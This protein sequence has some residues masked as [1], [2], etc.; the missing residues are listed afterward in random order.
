MLCSSSFRV[1]TETAQRRKQTNRVVIPH[2]LLDRH[3]DEGESFVDRT[4]AKD[5]ARI[6]HFEQKAKGGASIHSK[7]RARP[8]QKIMKLQFCES[9]NVHHYNIRRRVKHEYSLMHIS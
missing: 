5:K 8:R 9:H 3:A 7:N 1:C 4:V 2:R 6:H